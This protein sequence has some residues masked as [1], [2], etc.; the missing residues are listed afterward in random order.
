M[1]DFIKE[2]SL[3]QWV[4]IAGGVLLIFP[5]IKDFFV[6]G[7]DEEDTPNVDYPIKNIEN[8]N[9]LTSIVYKWEVLYN[10]CSDMNLINAQEKLEEVFPM[11]AKLRDSSPAKKVNKQEEQSSYG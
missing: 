8:S 7:D 1:I 4:L 6:D 11:F 9:A 3:F 10:A 5:I 2:L